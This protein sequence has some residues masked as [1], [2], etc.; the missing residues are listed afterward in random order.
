MSS[1]PHDLYI[2]AVVDALTA[3][4]LEPAT[5]QMA[6]DALSRLHGDVR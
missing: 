6:G 1:L 2:E 4:G 5:A 3:A